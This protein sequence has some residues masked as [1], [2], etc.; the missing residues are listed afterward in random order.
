MLA[1]LS[2]PVKAG[3]LCLIAITLLFAG[4]TQSHA[5]NIKK[6]LEPVMGKSEP[7]K[8]LIREKWAFIVGNNRFADTSVGPLKYAQKSAADVARA[9]KDPDAG[10]FPTDHVLTFNGP[11]ATKANIETGLE[12]WLYKKALPNDLVI[13]YLSSRILPAPETQEPILFSNDTKTDSIDK[14]GINLYEMLKTIKQRIRSEHIICLLD[15]H[16]LDDNS[17]KKEQLKDIKWLATSGVTI[18]A[19]NGLF[20]P[21][22]DDQPSLSSVFSHYFNEVLKGSQGNL[23]FFMMAEY[24]FQKT[25]EETKGAQ[26]PLMALSSPQ[27]HTASLVIGAATKSNAPNVSVGHPLDSLALSRPDIVAPK[28]AMNNIPKIEKAAVP[29]RT[30][31]PADDDEDDQVNHNLDFGS[32]MTKMKQDIQKKWLPPKGL[33]TRRVTAVFT[34]MANGTIND[35]SICDS[36][37]N[38]EMDKSA[39]AALQAASPLDP[40]PKGAPRSVDIRYVFDWKSSIKQ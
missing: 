39:M 22:I 29:A 14:T 25:Q 38:D 9:L 16:P 6:M 7:E 19:A 20:Q 23:P 33:E 37:G 3:A 17:G 28:T 32:Y 21:S 24:V 10:R 2:L 36:S 15:C 1:R 4:Q 26:K 18:F 31:K 13:I 11:D 5:G 30:V 27:S 40:L 34:I 35:P 8:P 12:Q